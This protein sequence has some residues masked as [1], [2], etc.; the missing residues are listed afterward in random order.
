MRSMLHAMMFAVFAGPLLAIYYGETRDEVIKELGKPTSALN[1]GAREILIYPKG[2]RIELEGGKVVVVQGLPVT[3]GPTAL[4]VAAE[5]NSPSTPPEPAAAEAPKETPEQKAER[6]ALEKAQQEME[7]ERA[8]QQAE[9]EKALKDLESGQGEEY[10]P[11]SLAEQWTELLTGLFVKAL[12]MLAALKLTTKYWDMPIEWSGLA[13]AAGADTAVR[14]VIG[15][16]GEFVLKLPTLFYVDEMIAAFV[17][18]AVLRKVSHNKSL[19]RAVTLTM[20][21][22]VFSIVVGSMVAVA[23]MNGLFR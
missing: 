5:P 12:L 3:D 13:I 16:I 23:V 11:P 10:Q 18:V 20:S 19:A 15:A 7:A 2:G 4:A 8:K 9:L 22:K 1:R 6:A 14:F 21:V 17:L